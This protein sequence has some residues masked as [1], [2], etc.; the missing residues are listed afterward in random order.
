MVTAEKNSMELNKL[1]RSGD[2]TNLTE[3]YIIIYMERKHEFFDQSLNE[4]IFR[5][6]KREMEIFINGFICGRT[7]QG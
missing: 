4:V 3:R 7:T 1:L 6:T 5:G 2:G